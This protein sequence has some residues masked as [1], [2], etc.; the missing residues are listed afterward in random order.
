MNKVALISF[1]KV[2]GKEVPIC[3]HLFVFNFC[4]FT[5]KNYFAMNPY[6]AFFVNSFVQKSH[7][8]NYGQYY[9]ICVRNLWTTVEIVK[10]KLRANPQ[11]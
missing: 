9:Q 7:F 6:E 2:I 8:E 5:F 3:K 4:L 10:F 11:S 1:L